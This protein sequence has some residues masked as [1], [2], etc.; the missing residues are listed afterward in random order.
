MLYHDGSSRDSV[1]PILRNF[2]ETTDIWLFFFM[3]T[4]FYDHWCWFIRVSQMKETGIPSPRIKSS[5]IATSYAWWQVYS[6]LAFFNGWRSI[7]EDSIPGDAFYCCRDIQPTSTRTLSS[8]FQ[9]QHNVSQ[10][11]SQNLPMLDVLD[12]GSQVSQLCVPQAK[13]MRRLRGKTYP[14]ICHG[15]NWVSQSDHIL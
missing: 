6:T 14:S 8:V 2:G 3:D 7:A 5:M 13:H 11:S 9:V 1:R 4:E 12:T 10:W 15:P